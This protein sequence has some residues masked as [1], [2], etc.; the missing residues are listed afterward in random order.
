MDKRAGPPA[1]SS[2]LAWFCQLE[3]YGLSEC[4]TLSINIGLGALGGTISGIRVKLFPVATWVMNCDIGAPRQEKQQ[5]GVDL[6]SA[7]DQPVRSPF[8]VSQNL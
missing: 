3:G 8:R 1:V 4:L 2:N 7:A 5:R 6:V